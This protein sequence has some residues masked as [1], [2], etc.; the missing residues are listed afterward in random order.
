MQ[1]TTKKGRIVN[2]PSIRLETERKCKNDSLKA[3]KWLLDTVRED[4]KDDAW[5]TL[6]L[7][8]MYPGRLTV[9]DKDILMDLLLPDGAS[10]YIYELV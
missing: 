7:E 2:T 6:L 3:D 8:D 9:S 5:I 10:K 4:Y 1:I